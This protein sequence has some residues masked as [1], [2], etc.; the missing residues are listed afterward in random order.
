ML[1]LVV[2]DVI[3]VACRHTVGT[4]VFFAVWERPSWLQMYG[5]CILEGMRHSI[6]LPGSCLWGMFLGRR[7]HHERCFCSWSCICVMLT[8]RICLWKRW[9]FAYVGIV[10]ANLTDL[11]TVYLTVRR[12]DWE[13][14]G[15]TVCQCTTREA[16][17]VGIHCSQHSSCIWPLVD[18][19]MSLS[20]LEYRGPLSIGRCGCKVSRL[21]KN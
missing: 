15:T 6:C 11:L 9:V 2:S 21:A 8:D 13:D 16:K 7:C 12:S 18:W 10:C 19:H 14:E 1:L 4:D 20:L 17:S 5:W 3:L